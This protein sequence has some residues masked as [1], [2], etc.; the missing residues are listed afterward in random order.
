VE[1]AVTDAQD[2]QT[3]TT[4]MLYTAFRNHVALKHSE[5]EALRAS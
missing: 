5:G 4:E 3:E 1:K 2:T